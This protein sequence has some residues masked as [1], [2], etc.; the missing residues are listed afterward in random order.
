MVICNNVH[1]LRVN[2]QFPHLHTN[3]A[4]RKTFIS[5]RH[6]PNLHAA[7][8]TELSATEMSLLEAQ[9]SATECTVGLSSELHIK[10]YLT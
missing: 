6:G 7:N 9:V 4:Q 3:D 5:I 10:L 8:C 1:G 2:S